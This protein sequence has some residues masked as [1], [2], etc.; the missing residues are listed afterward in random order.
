MDSALIAFSGGVDSTFLLKVAVDMLPKNKLLAVTA[1]SATYPAEELKFAKK[2][3]Q[4]IGARHEVIK[5]D[6]IRNPRFVSNPINRCYFC[7]K[8]LFTHL[9]SL[10]RKNKLNFVLDASN[11]SDKNDYRPGA[12]AKN[13]LRI[14][15]PLEEAGLS[16]EGIRKLSKNLG[17]VT[18]D[19]PALACL[20]SRIPYG[21]K[22]TPAILSRINKAE[23]F[24][25]QLN[26]KQVRVRHYERF[27][28][29]EVGRDQV[30]K[31]I[32]K[33]V[34]VVE[35]L[36]KLGYNYIT[37]DLQGYRVGSMNEG[38]NK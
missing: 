29:I 12:Q 14:R 36:K 9:K 10:A 35:K 24:L 17:L 3:A 25:R 26:I 7:K 1:T 32:R 18:W 4:S 5:T 30:P 20:A 37:V 22:I 13:E 38:L 8:E 31:L 33:R 16:K 21:V 2:I 23:K 11:I 6:E 28:R 19:K 15:S 27:C 34:L